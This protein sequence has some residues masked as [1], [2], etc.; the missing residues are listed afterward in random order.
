MGFLQFHTIPISC[1]QQRGGIWGLT[2]M[3]VQL[4]TLPFQ[5]L[6]QGASFVALFHSVLFLNYPFLKYRCATLFALL[7]LFLRIHYLFGC[8]VWLMYTCFWIVLHC[9]AI[10]IVDSFFWVSFSHCIFPSFLQSCFSNLFERFSSHNPVANGSG[11]Y[12]PFPFFAVLGL[13]QSF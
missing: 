9:I 10:C 1:H 12:S 13:I 5:S 3:R 2:P 7:S 8:P 6:I 11:S 4:R